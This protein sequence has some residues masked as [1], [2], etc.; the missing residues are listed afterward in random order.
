M[1]LAGRVYY[2]WVVVAACFLGSFVVFGLSYSFG[3]FFEPILAEFGRSRGVTSVAFG[4][5]S[6]MLYLGAVG[7][8]VLVDRYGTRRMLAAGA[9]V[10][11]FG[12][13]ATSRAQSLLVLVF[14]YGIVT[15]LGMSV[16]FVVS[17]ATVPRWFDRRQGLA[18]GL[19]SAGLGMGMVVVAPA[20]DALIVRV[21]WRSALSI[22]A[23]GAVALLAVAIVAVRDEPAPA[24]VPA[25][26][27]DRGVRASERPPLRD[28]LAAVRAIAGSPAFLAQF[29]G[30]LLIYTTLY[31]VLS[32]LV[33]HAVDLGLSRTVGAS[34]VALIGG[35]SVVG[36]VAIGHA[37]DRIG[38]VST[39]AAC[40]AVMGGA[41]I[42]LPALDTAA[43][44]FAFAGVYGL[45]YGGNGALLAPLTADLFGR[46]NINAVFGLVSVSLGLSGLV[47][48]Y[49]A[50]AGHDAIG[51]YSP[52]FVAA[53]VLALVGAGAI[54]AAGRFST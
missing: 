37:A 41:A 31:V 4:V 16:L 6:L 20:A 5:Q 29:V 49:L 28:Q 33:V 14:T 19:A 48:P 26:E 24:Q 18:G 51:T 36:R 11:V 44:L 10:L 32:H 34:A 52:A 23:A 53:G 2:G 54:V 39:F 12:L 35:A 38:R 8:G 1:S 46:E 50:G 7:I 25:R 13:L 40:S 21:G 42:A 22:L 43:A 27:F 47:S 3:V 9:V 30:W 15:G 17:Y 45:A